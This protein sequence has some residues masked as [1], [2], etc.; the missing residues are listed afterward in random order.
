MRMWEGSFDVQV[1][2]RF[3]YQDEE[4]EVTAVYPPQHGFFICELK[5]VQ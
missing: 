1:G 5:L 2:H 4:I 3:T